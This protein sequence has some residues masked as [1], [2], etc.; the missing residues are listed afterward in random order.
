MTSPRTPIQPPTPPP[1]QR[2]DQTFW[3]RAGQVI[4]HGWG[5]MTELTKV[6]LVACTTVLLATTLFS[7]FYN[8]VPVPSGAIYVVNKYTGGVTFCPGSFCNELGPPPRSR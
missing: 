6:T 3:V 5:K 1:D 4:A 2:R 8:V 7:G